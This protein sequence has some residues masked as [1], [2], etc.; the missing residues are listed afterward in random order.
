AA[1]PTSVLGHSKRVAEK[2]TAWASETSD[3][4][5]LSVRFGNVIGSRGSMLPTFARLIE[6]GGPLTVTHP[7]VTRFFMTIPEAC[8][9]VIQAGAIG[10]PGEVLIL[11]MG[12]PVRILDVAQRMIEMSGK[13]IAITFTGL[14]EG[15]KL[16]EEL[17]GSSESD[18]RPRHPKISHARV[19]AL[20]PE[21]LDKTEWLRR[22]RQSSE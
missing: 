7:D 10:E 8:Q 6:Q 19:E 18:A 20:S 1:N 16:H 21:R 3:G 5:Y 15:E 14:R 13:D 12:E 22:C 2:L 4:T 11:D 9:L 17:I